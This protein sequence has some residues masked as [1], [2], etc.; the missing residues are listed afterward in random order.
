MARADIFAQSP[1]LARLDA[2]ARAEVLANATRFALDSGQVLFRQGDVADALYILESGRLGIETRLPGDDT[3]ALSPILPGEVVGEFALLD[4]APRSAR[5]TALL[6]SEGLRISRARF[7][8]LLADAQPGTVQ[9]AAGLR[10][11]VATRTRA[12]LARIA[13]EGRFEPSSLRRA[14]SFMAKPVPVAGDAAALLAGLGK[15][16]DL[17]PDGARALATPSRMVGVERG[18]GLV[19]IN[20][21]TPN[22]LW[23]VLRGALRASMARTGGAEQISIHGPGEC[24]NVIALEDG[25]APSLDIAAAEDCVLLRVPG[26]VLQP[27]LQPDSTNDSGSANDWHG[28][29]ALVLGRQLVRDQRRANRHLGRALALERFN[30]GGL[31]GHA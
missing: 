27:V 19:C 2:L 20:D 22:T 23:I 26:K 9:L 24:V 1:Q 5:V 14:I 6:P 8:A 31:G 4:D 30:L 29:L 17:G 16:A 28:A 7:H 25:A 18:Q 21:D 12:T 11:L 13:A 3:A 10:R 15:L